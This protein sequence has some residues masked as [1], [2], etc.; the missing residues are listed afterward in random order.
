MVPKPLSLS[1]HVTSAFLFLHH[2]LPPETPLFSLVCLPISPLPIGDSSPPPLCSLTALSAGCHHCHPITEQTCTASA[3]YSPGVPQLASI[4]PPMTCLGCLTW[5]LQFR[6]ASSMVLKLNLLQECDT[7]SLGL[8][9]KLG[10]Q[11]SGASSLPAKEWKRPALLSLPQPLLRQYHSQPG[12]N[13]WSCSQ[14]GMKLARRKQEQKIIQATR[15]SGNGAKEVW[16]IV[17]NIRETRCTFHGAT[18][19]VYG[20][21]N[22]GDLLYATAQSIREL[23]YTSGHQ[24]DL[25]YSSEQRGFM[26]SSEHQRDLVYSSWSRE[27]QSTLQG[28]R[29]IWLQFRASEKFDVQFRESERLGVQFRASE[30]FDVQFRAP[31]RFDIQFRAS[32]RFGYSSWHQR[33]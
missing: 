15:P 6:D 1:R 29:E 10:H 25:V 26:Y 2:F 3:F 28:T 9:L 4:D 14:L 12:E 22:L 11:I 21:R 33:N 18:E 30:R 32:E 8:V 20:L 16:Y 27:T 13:I 7:A 31:E 23:E 17:Q 5:S 24:R 19:T